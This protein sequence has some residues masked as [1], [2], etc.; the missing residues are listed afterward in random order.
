MNRMLR[1]FDSGSVAEQASIW[2]AG[3]RR[4][5]ASHAKVKKLG[6]HV[7]VK[8]P[9]LGPLQWKHARAIGVAARDASKNLCG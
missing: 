9:V 5:A 1:W 6:F 2:A 7:V 3:F 4:A 8:I